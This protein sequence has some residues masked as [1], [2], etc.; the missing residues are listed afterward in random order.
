MTVTL[1][2]TN[3]SDRRV[4]LEDRDQLRFL[5]VRAGDDVLNSSYLWL[6]DT[7]LEPG[8]QHTMTRSWTPEFAPDPDRPATLVAVIAESVDSFN[9]AQTTVG[10]VEGVPALMLPVAPA[11]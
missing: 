2:V 7:A 10:V 1:T 9:R 8:E 4:A 11:A 3:A 5:G 6:G